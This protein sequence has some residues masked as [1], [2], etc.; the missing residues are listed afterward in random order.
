MHG[1]NRLRIRKLKKFWLRSCSAFEFGAFVT[2]SDAA[3]RVEDTRRRSPLAAM[4]PTGQAI[5]SN[6]SRV[7]RYVDD[8]T[9]LYDPNPFGSGRRNAFA[10]EDAYVNGAHGPPPISTRP[11][12][13]AS[14]PPAYTPAPRASLP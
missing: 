8:L 10:A 1:R 11:P 3:P 7:V 9:R 6:R 14:N 2:E 12:A 13:I 4:S 5:A